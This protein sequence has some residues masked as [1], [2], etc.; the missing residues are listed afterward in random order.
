MAASAKHFS[1]LICLALFSSLHAHARESQFFSKV[2]TPAT[3]NPKETVEVPNNEQPLSKQ[4]QD[5]NFIPDTQNGYGLYSQE[6]DQFPPTTT[7]N[8]PSTASNLP[9]KTES[10]QPYDDDVKQ[11]YVTN[12]QGMS[13]TRFMDR[14]YTNNNNKRAYVTNPQGMSDTRFMDRGY[15]TST[16]TNN[17]N[18]YMNK[19]HSTAATDN[20][21]N[22]GHNY[23]PQQQGMSDTRFLENGRYFYDIQSENNYNNGYGSSR[24]VD[25]YNK[26][27]YGNSYNE[28]SY[29]VNNSMEGYQNQEQF[30]E[31]QEEYVP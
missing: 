17:N 25:N 22:G 3:A 20:Y 11:A 12:P 29:V 2:T 10:E 1:F 7:T 4:E 18:Y 9:Y 15:T 24:G 6:T 27:Y 21:Y 14:G 19:G 28:N 31:D 13:D 23:N 5:P 26:G 30:Q 16:S 8:P